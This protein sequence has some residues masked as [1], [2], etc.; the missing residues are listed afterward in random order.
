MCG[1]PMRLAVTVLLAGVAVQGWAQDKKGS[2]GQK[3][4]E[5]NAQGWL[6]SDPL[7][8]ERCKG[9]VVVLEFWATW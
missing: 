3:P 6:N 7:T 2:V 4:K 5:I 9:K 1:F 8:L